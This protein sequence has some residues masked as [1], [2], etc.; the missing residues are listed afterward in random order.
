MMLWRSATGSIRIRSRSGASAPPSP[1][2][3][4]P[5]AGS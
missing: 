4:Q 1:T 5:K 3:G 2:C